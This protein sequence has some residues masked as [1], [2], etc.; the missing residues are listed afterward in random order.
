MKKKTNNPTPA[1][2]TAP[3]MISVGPV[4]GRFVGGVLGVGVTLDVPDGVGEADVLGLGV[5]VCEA[6]GVGVGV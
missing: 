1:I 3:K 6:L 4:G 2:A 5:G